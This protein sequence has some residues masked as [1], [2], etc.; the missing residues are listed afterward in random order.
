MY[1]CGYS[2]EQIL[3]KRLPQKLLERGI[4][5]TFILGLYAM[6]ERKGDDTSILVYGRRQGEE[7]PRAWIEYKKASGKRYVLDYGSDFIEMSYTAYHNKYFPDTERLYL[8]YIFWTRYTNH[9]H[10]LIK[11]PETSYIID[12]L[13]PIY[14]KLTN[15]RLLGITEFRYDHIDAVTGTEFLPTEIKNPDDKLVLLTLDLF[16][17]LME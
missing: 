2:T 1:L 16:H 14:P 12:A 4:N 8:D 3:E 15:G 10:E 5:I 11:Q 17:E 6:L 9:L 7:Y 13:K